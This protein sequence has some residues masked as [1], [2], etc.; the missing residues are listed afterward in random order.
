MSGLEHA[1]RNAL[2]RADRSDPEIR[3]RIYQSARHALDAGLAKQEVEDEDIIARQRQRLDATILAIEEEERERL[4]AMARLE[5]VL[6][7]RE[8]D[9]EPMI[10]AEPRSAEPGRKED[11]SVSAPD[12]NAPDVDDR[13]G[14]PRSAPSIELN[15]DDRV[16]GARQDTGSLDDFAPRGDEAM[17]RLVADERRQ[18]ANAP[19]G[20]TRSGKAKTKS[21]KRKAVIEK[22]ARKRRGLVAFFISLFV[23]SCFVGAI[24][25]GVWWVYATGMIDVALKGEGNFDLVP[26]ELQTAAPAATQSEPLDPLRRF[27]GDWVNVYTGKEA[28][29]ISPRG[30]ALVSSFSDSDGEGVTIVSDAPGKEGEVLVETPEELLQTLAGKTATIALTVKS[31]GETPTQIYVECDFGTLGGCGRHRF[32]V[33]NE[34]TD[35]LIHLTFDG[36]MA[37]SEAGQIIVNSDV[38]GKGRKLKL[39]GVR[40]LPGS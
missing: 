38:M 30:A 4:R 32:T 2:E 21:G 39:Y 36:K 18:S 25:F 37:P 3:A 12:V 8:P 10:A 14:S 15:H 20:E 9:P 29:A 27:S 28:N 23:Y 40:V 6:I 35:E 34:R 26:K 33:G 5:K 19:I 17:A 31:D 22:P 13:R 1:I 11:F 24:A 16:G 7:E